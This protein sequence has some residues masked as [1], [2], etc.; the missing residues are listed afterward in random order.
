MRQFCVGPPSALLI[1]GNLEL[2]DRISVRR[3]DSEWC[4][5]LKREKREGI[6]GYVGGHVQYL[7]IP[8]RSRVGRQREERE[9]EDLIGRPG[10]CALGRRSIRRRDG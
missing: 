1:R 10:R 4:H 6:P 5:G 3:P 8:R 9:A 7:V 2:P